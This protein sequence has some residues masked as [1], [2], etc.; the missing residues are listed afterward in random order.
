MIKLQLPAHKRPAY[1]SRR[2]GGGGCSKMAQFTIPVWDVKTPRRK[3][4]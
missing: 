3:L 4:P 2:L 1:V